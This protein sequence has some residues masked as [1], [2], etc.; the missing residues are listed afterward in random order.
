MRQ[1]ILISLLFIL[2]I[3]FVFPFM[4]IQTHAQSLS[5][6][7]EPPIIQI[8]AKRPASIKTPITLENTSQ[9]PVRLLIS[10]K[11][12]TASEE[13]NGLVQYF[14]DGSAEAK[15]PLFQYIQFADGDHNTN[16]VNLAPNQSKSITMHIGIPDNFDLGDYYFSVVFI[17]IPDNSDT[18]TT[19]LQASGGIATNVLLT[20]GPTGATTGQITDFSTPF[21]V[22]HGPVPFTVRLKNT[23]DHYITP[24][25]EILITNMFGQTIGRV[26]LLPVNVLSHTT[27]A[28]PDSLLSPDASKSPTFVR[29]ITRYEAAVWPE[30]FLLGPYTAQLTIALSNQGPV[31]RRTIYFFAFPWY[32]TLLLFIVILLAIFLWYRVKKRLNK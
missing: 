28:L 14:P 2:L 6:G 1:K 16:I 5:L 25:G 17:S 32:F 20:L 10:L 19:S 7:I 23:S 27:R 4:I 9:N 8:D 11:P 22:E 15:S 29:P 21:F 31:F 3:M 30:S 13:E 26:N 12:F 18:K 24:K